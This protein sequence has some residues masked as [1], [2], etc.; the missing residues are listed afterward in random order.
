M[1]EEVNLSNWLNADQQEAGDDKLLVRFYLR[2]V[3]N[4]LK[5][6]GGELLIQGPNDP[7]LK[8][9]QATAEASGY[10]V[11]VDLSDPK[12]KKAVVIGAGRPIFDEVEYVFIKAPDKIDK[13][14]EVDRPARNRDRIRFRKQYEA[15]KFANTE[16][17]TGT[18]LARWPLITATQVEELKYLKI[19][20]E[21]HPVRTV[22][23]LAE[24][25][26][27]F[28]PY[29]GALGALKKK[30]QDY[31]A[32]A[33]GQAPMVG[34]RAELDKRGVEMAELRR[35]LDE[36]SKLIQSLTP[37]HTPTGPVELVPAH[38][39]VTEATKKPGR[40]KKQIAE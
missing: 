9:L 10:R 37:N 34:M 38:V 39:S 30:A 18:P 35:M 4:K 22:E 29:L 23:Q 12:N 40:P 17:A 25:P 21:P 15:Y 8:A 13:Y 7:K 28:M 5:T 14:S 1:L 20:G 6:E 33:R 16:A 26:E 24:F 19:D 31:L 3:Q 32:H 2:P 36:Q 27:G 11:E